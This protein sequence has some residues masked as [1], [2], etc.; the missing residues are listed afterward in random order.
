MLITDE[1]RNL[2]WYDMGAPLESEK[3][4]L[5]DEYFA[6]AFLRYCY[7]E[8]YKNY[9]KADGPDI[10]RIDGKCGVEVTLAISSVIAPI[11][12]NMAKFQLQTDQEKKAV[13]K[14]KIEKGG[15][16]FDSIGISYPVET[17]EQ[18]CDAIRTVI[19]KKVERLTFYHKKGFKKMELFIRSSSIPCILSDIK[20]LSLFEK[21]KGY[22]TVYFTAPSCLLSYHHSDKKLVCKKINRED[23]DAL[24]AIARLTVDGKINT[25]SNIWNAY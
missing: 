1:I 13:L 21:A 25:E 18:D 10:Q 3:M 14:S 2:Q 17:E 8:K 15:A 4:K 7:P 11:E 12:G 22:E 23:Y 9:I 24:S 16:R 6:L 20:Y 19:D 5:F